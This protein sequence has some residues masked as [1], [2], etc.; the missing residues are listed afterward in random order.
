MN[1]LNVDKVEHRRV[2]AWFLGP[3][4]ENEN[5]FLELFKQVLHSHSDWRRQYFPQVCVLK[6]FQ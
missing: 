3:K 5:E 1:P 4:A 6:Q 2:A